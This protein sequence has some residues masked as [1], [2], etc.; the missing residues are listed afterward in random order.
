MKRCAC[1][2]RVT[3]SKFARLCNGCLK[4]NH[5]ARNAR[6]KHYRGW[7]HAGETEAEV[8]QL[9][10]DVARTAFIRAHLKEKSA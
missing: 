7:Y 4:A 5:L 1:G 3:K 2:K 6:W 9:F 10:R 8:E